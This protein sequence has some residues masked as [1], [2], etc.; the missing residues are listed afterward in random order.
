MSAHSHMQNLKVD[1]KMNK[2]SAIFLGLLVIGISVSSYLVYYHYAARAGSE[3]WCNINSQINCNNVIL[4]KYS[5][6]FGIPLAAL[7]AAWFSICA[8]FRQVGAVLSITIFGANAPFYLFIWS[9]LGVAT[10]AGLVFLEIF[11]VGSICILCTICH[12]M[13]LG[14]F[15]ISYMS[16]KKPLSSY[17]KDVFYQ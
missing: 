12:I 15:V 16:L 4:S 17:V 7:G 13:A 1:G 6:V 8:I 2:M 9:S 3:S 14:I 10:V 5:E 11:S